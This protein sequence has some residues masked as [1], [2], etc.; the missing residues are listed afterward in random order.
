MTGGWWS[1]WRWKFGLIGRPA[2][3]AGVRA[4]LVFDGRC[5][6]DMVTVRTRHGHQLRPRPWGVLAARGEG[7]KGVEGAAAGEG[8]R[9]AVGSTTSPRWGQGVGFGRT[10][11]DAAGRG[12][13]MRHL[14]GWIGLHISFIRLD[15]DG[16]FENRYLW[17]N[18]A[19]SPQ[20]APGRS[21]AT[22]S[23]SV[24]KG[25]IQT[26]PPRKTPS[27]LPTTTNPPIFTWMHEWVAR[28]GSK[29]QLPE[30]RQKKHKGE[31]DTRAL[32]R[33]PEGHR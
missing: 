7:V 26:V 3:P 32:R 23:R 1:G 18:A 27:A 28:R 30:T 25:K 22:L 2:E 15:R 33:S 13:Q 6:V 29:T 20:G 24:N 17:S 10:G 31:G 8:F 5:R 14:T 19:V 16:N 4:G 11:T 21:N 9:G 12:S